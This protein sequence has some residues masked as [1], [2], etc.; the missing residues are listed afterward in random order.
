MRWWAQKMR[1]R[2]LKV[3]LFVL[4]PLLALA[5]SESTFHDSL[6]RHETS[7]NIELHGV[8][9][10]LPPDS[11]N[12]S[13]ELS[14][15]RL[16]G[17]VQKVDCQPSGAFDFVQLPAG[18]YQLTVFLGAQQ[19][20]QQITLQAPHEELAIELANAQPAASSGEQT[21]SVAELQLPSKARE[22]FQKA[23]EMMAEQKWDKADKHVLEALKSAPKYGKALA[24]RAMLL[25]IN[26]D[27]SS[28]L[29]FATQA[30][31]ADP[32]LAVAQTVR[33]AALNA[34]G[35]T[36]PAQLAAEQS[37][38]I[39]DSW[40]ARFELAK[41]L[42]GEGHLRHGL[43]ELNRAGD[44]A[45]QSTADIYLV[46]AAVLFNLKDLQGS[47][48]N[49]EEFSKLRPADPRGAKLNSLLAAGAR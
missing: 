45:P 17:V 37:L 28:A 46:R 36:Q 10:G 48:Q 2:F 4:V 30:V 19:V 39:S 1:S 49:L 31:T 20:S 34:T 29:S 40:Q 38:R 33:A 43:A 18:D 13:I 21:V 32:M 7:Q 41:A 14:E 22:E 12:C 26:K 8:I 24:L 42:I 25:L 47:R 6:P 3:S 27:F 15:N 11:H 9:R 35:Q 23:S 16:G 44:A 5:Q